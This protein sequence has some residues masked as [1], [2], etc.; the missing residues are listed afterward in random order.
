MDEDPKFK[1]VYGGS[2]T[3]PQGDIDDC[4]AVVKV[5]RED[6]EDPREELLAYVDT[7]RLADILLDDLVAEPGPYVEGEE[8]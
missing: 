4:W 1:K 5:I 3:G 7:E 8:Y 6:G 2:A